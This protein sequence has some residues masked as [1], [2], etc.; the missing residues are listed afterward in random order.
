MSQQLEA[1]SK[2]NEIRA[3]NAEVKRQIRAG[4]MTV[5]EAIYTE[6]IG[7]MKVA[8]LIEAQDYWGPTKSRKLL[9]FIGASRALRVRD[10]TDRQRDLLAMGTEQC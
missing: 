7:S 2:A 4:E 8:S 9:A 6:E 10:L 5:A 1:L 3:R